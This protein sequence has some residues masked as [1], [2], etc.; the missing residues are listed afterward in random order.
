MGNFN[1]YE[2]LGVENE[3]QKKLKLKKVSIER[4]LIDESQT[5]KT[6]KQYNE[7][8]TV[9]DNEDATKKMM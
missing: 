9:T 7:E 3:K 8:T 5:N 4:K 2:D 1:S 6:V